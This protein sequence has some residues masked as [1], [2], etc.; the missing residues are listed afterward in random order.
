MARILLLNPNTDTFGRHSIPIGY[1]TAILKERGHAVC[2]FDTTFLD[3]NY[4]FNKENHHT[5][6]ENLSFFKPVDLSPFDLK[7]KKVD[8]VKLFEEKL[9]AFSPDAI[10]FSFWG[11]QRH[12]GGEFVA[13]FNALKILE[14]SNIKEIPVFVGGI[15]P[16]WDAKEAIKNP[17][18]RG[19]IRG[20]GEFAF[21]DIAD[22]LE[23]RQDYS[24]VLNLWCKRSDGKIIENPMRALVDVLDK[25]PHAD[26]SLYEEKTFLR[27]YHG[28][29][30][31]S[32]DFELSRGCYYD[33]TFCLSP[34][35][36]KTYDSPKNFRR[37]KSVQKIIGEI[38]LLKKKH[39]LDFIRYNDEIFLGMSDEKLIELAERYSKEVNL[40]FVIETTVR[41]ITPERIKLL[42]KMG[43][44]SISLG[45]ES[46]SKFMRDT[47]CKKPQ[48][49]NDELV[50]KVKI[51][52][53]A[54]ISCNLFNIIAFPCETEAM[55]FETIELNHQAKP[56]YCMVGFFQPW[57][58]T[59][60]RDYCV[61]NGLLDGNLKGLENSS[62]NLKGNK[63]TGKNIGDDRLI[64][65]H[66]KFIFFVYLPKVLWP[67]VERIFENNFPSKILLKVFSVILRLRFRLIP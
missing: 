62:D 42:K 3:T 32:L 45:V 58:G 30:L 19:V 22:R 8:V 46:G 9:N 48:F 50:K 34:F 53:K 57:E 5:L 29:I 1:L 10:F 51:I 35:Q 12:A 43:C 33:C 11:S 39:S 27:P 4:L 59:S 26:F 36:R 61:N 38:S 49:E 52:K 64:D 28:K 20:E 41:S 37:E 40:P 63:L 56:P 15:V 54:G 24:D 18:I 65:L 7:K 17:M 21:A 55:I 66:K 47:V 6:L 31:R 60:L 16:T 2:L 44:L 23:A 13:Y 14:K 25:I 67:L